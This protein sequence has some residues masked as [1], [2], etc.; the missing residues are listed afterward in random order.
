[1]LLPACFLLFASAP[2]PSAQFTDYTARVA[3]ESAAGLHQMAT[4]AG[5]GNGV[6]VVD[7]YADVGLNFL[8]GDDIVEV[9]HLHVRDGVGLDCQGAVEIRFDPPARAF[10]CDFPGGAQ[11][12][13]FSGATLLHSS[14]DFG[15]AAT[16]NFGGVVSTSVFD[17]VVIRDWMDGLLHLDD[18]RVA[19]PFSLLVLGR[20]PGPM[21]VRT[22][23]GMPG[24]PT[25]LIS[26][27]PG[28]SVIPPGPCA[29]TPLSLSRPTLRKL[30]FSDARGATV[31]S[32]FAIPGACGLTIQAVD[33]RTCR[34]SGTGT[35]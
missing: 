8:D 22:L 31:S 12:S 20:C 18:L 25:A 24:G 10:A 15:G 1:M 28:S 33:V 16:D 21:T 4:F 29:G 35:L 23:S 30:L 3:W 19:H 26:G 2:A 17:R 11:M 27:L 14:R 9:S 13:F 5:L 6:L 7:Q 34:V 32:F